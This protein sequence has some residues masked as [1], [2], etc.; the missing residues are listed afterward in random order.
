MRFGI[1]LNMQN[2]HVS[3]VLRLIRSKQNK[4][5]QQKLIEL[6]TVIQSMA[7]TLAIFSLR[8]NCF[9]IHPLSPSLP[10][11]WCLANFANYS[12][13]DGV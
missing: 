7:Q 9:F 13:V 8:C 1:Q 11:T 10:L 3:A 6:A 12:N 5:Q 4:R 2:R